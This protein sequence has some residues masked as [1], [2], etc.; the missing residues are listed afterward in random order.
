MQLKI[1]EFNAQ[2]LFLQLAYPVNADILK[3]LNEDEW[4]YY[5]KDE[6]V[7]KPLFK[8]R[9]IAA[10]IRDEAPDLIGMTEVGGQ[11]SAQNFVDLFLNGEYEVFATP[12]QS[13]RGIENIFLLKRSL[14]LKAKVKSHRDWPTPFLYRHET[15]P[16][17]HA[18][19]VAA[20]DYADLGK[21]ETRKLSRD[22]PLLYLGGKKPILAALLVHLKSGF[23]PEG[24][25]P[26]GHLRRRAELL[27]LLDIAA[28]VPAS[29]P[30]VI[31]GDFNG[32]ASRIETSD[33]FEPLYS[34]TDWEDVLELAGIAK[35]ERHTHVTFFARSFTS[36]QLDYIFL[37][38]DLKKRLVP[39]STRV[40]RYRF[41]EEDGE[42]MVPFSFR[43]RA[44]LP[45]D[46]YPI[47]CTL[48]LSKTAS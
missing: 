22:I 4:Q 18:T 34:Q 31:L 39:G 32:H 41:S 19:A 17:A 45:S 15:D 14:K 26:E 46:H 42:M 6:V 38:G 30:L 21:P 25:D 24:F 27:A 2:D 48:D 37:R 43:E 12:G 44:L 47:L 3:S 8:L 28:T 9:A 23:D 35:H 40:Y 13:D 16:E 29:V 5:A 33:E 20:A 7:L 11:E 1:M 36:S 10:I